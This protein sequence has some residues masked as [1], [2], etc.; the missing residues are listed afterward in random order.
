MRGDGSALTA[1]CYVKHCKQTKLQMVKLLIDAKA[2]V[3]MRVPFGE[4]SNWHSRAIETP[5]HAAVHA[6]PVGQGG[7]GGKEHVESCAE[8]IVLLL[9]ARADPE[10]QNSSGK[11]AIDFAQSLPKR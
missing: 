11:R 7:L 5:L 6:R 3:N 4:H 2:D 10:L 1:A 9:E 8:C